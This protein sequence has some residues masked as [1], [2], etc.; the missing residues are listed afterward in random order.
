MHK[1]AQVLMAQ[2]RRACAAVAQGDFSPIVLER[3]EWVTGE[4]GWMLGRPNGNGITWT[5]QRA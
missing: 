2:A 1:P 4:T 3:Y 5:R